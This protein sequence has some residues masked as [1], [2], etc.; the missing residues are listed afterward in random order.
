MFIWIKNIHLKNYKQVHREI[1]K[2]KH[3]SKSRLY[4]CEDH[5]CVSTIITITNE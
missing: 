1:N 3:I 2:F 4:C 5:V